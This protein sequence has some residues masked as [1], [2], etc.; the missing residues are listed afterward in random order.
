MRIRVTGHSAE[1]CFPFGTGGPWKKFANVILNQGYQLCDSDLAQP[2]DVLIANTHHKK[3]MD[4][5]EI[6]DIPKERRVLILWEPYVVETTRY[7]PEV[8]QNYG[9]IYAPSINWARRINAQPFN[10]PQDAIEPNL[11]IFNLW[12][13]RIS[14]CV[15]LQGNKY[16]CRK[17]EL[18][19]LRRKV[20]RRMKIE[21]LSLYGTN[22]NRGIGFD[23]WQWSRTILNSKIRDID[24]KS[25]YGMGRKYKNY[26]GS[27]NE[28]ELTLRKFKISIVIENSA[29]FISEKLFDSVRAGCVTVYVGPPLQE[30]GIPSDAAIQLE[31]NGIKIAE[32]IQELL[33]NPDEELEKIARKQYRQLQTVTSSWEN[34][35]VLENLASDLLLRLSK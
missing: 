14:S 4:Y 27:V 5:C 21:E 31:P 25:C 16:S 8:L 26:A 33:S 30:F 1:D 29:D 17:G 11:E 35:T 34:N 6:N 24:L 9:H 13:E 22:W 2:A 19:S 12:S 28:K 32:A 18:Y 15:M 10:W 20:L 23:W 3:F 7:K